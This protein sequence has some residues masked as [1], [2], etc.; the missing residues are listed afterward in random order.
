V[1][2]EYERI[3]EAAARIG[4]PARAVVV[5]SSDEAAMQKL[6][7]GVE[8]VDHIFSN[9]GSVVG[10]AKL[11]AEIAA[12]RPAMDVRFW[13]AVYA[14][15]SG[16]AKMRAGGSIVVM[17]GTA[18]VRP[19]PGSSVGSAS[20]AAVESLARSLAIDLAPI[21]VNAIRPGLI[22]TPLVDRLAGERKEAFMKNYAARLP[23]KRIGRAEEV[24]DAVLFLMKNGFVTGIT[25]AIDGG[26]SLV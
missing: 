22:D 24:A 1:A 9:A 25:L 16:A 26:G 7:A 11:T 10:D 3:S 18:A 20:C 15:K 5:D 17:S 12:M 21:R 14:A 4:R 13:G 2:Y 6:F 23:L 8:A 19:I